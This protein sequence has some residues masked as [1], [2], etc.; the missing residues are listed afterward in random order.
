MTKEETAKVQGLLNKV[1]KVTCA[2]RHSQNVSARYMEELS[3]RQS[4]FEDW[5]TK[6]IMKKMKKINFKE[7]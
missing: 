1:N 2:F 7:D 6:I 4:E 3:N 5:F